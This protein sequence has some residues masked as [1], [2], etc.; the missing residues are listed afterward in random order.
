MRNTVQPTRD[1]LT[2]ERGTRPIR[3]LARACQRYGL[4]LELISPAFGG[5]LADDEVSRPEVR[6][7]DGVASYFLPARWDIVDAIHRLPAA[8]RL[9]DG[10]G[11][12]L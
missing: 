12:Q 8:V 10:Q 2:D 9:A 5:A 1:A 3:L 6:T 4:L 11:A 7:V